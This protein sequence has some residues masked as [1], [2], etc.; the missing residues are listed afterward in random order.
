MTDLLDCTERSNIPIVNHAYTSGAHD[1][2]RPH[3][4]SFASL[5]DSPSMITGTDCDGRNIIARLK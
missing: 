2:T 1:G 5:P 3:F 4:M